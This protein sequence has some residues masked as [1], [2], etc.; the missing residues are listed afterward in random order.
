MAELA[1]C[2]RGNAVY[3]DQL[4]AVIN[5]T[6]LQTLQQ[7]SNILPDLN[8]VHSSQQTQGIC[9]THPFHS[10]HVVCAGMMDYCQPKV[11]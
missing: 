7:L 8:D 9:P 10:L 11:S 2:Q 4:D 6:G 3:E 5:H 1:P